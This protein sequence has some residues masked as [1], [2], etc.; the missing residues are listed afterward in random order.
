[1]GVNLGKRM[2][3]VAKTLP[4]KGFFIRLNSIPNTHD[5][6]ANNV[7]YHLKCWV[8]NVRETQRN[9]SKMEGK[10][11]DIDQMKDLT[12]IL[13]E[14]DIINMVKNILKENLEEIMTMSEINEEY[15]RLMN[16]KNLLNYKSY[17]K[18]LLLDNQRYF[19]GISANGKW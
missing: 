7:L 12:C 19:Q 8:R 14:I 5:A 18:Q 15:Y 11:N 16:N 9:V 17:I 3:D 2:L 4:E 10:D 6:V 1:M 13:A